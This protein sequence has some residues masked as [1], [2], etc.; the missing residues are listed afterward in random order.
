VEYDERCYG[1]FFQDNDGAA[2]KVPAVTHADPFI[3]EIDDSDCFTRLEEPAG[4]ETEPCPA[5][6]KSGC[7]KRREKIPEVRFRQR[8][9][10]GILT[11][12]LK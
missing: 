10:A 12:T 2:D 1:R 9:T 6:D 8:E 5:P 4:A 11:E 7:V 3:K